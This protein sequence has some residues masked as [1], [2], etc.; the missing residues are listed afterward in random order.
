MSIIKQK[1][2]LI[3]K[4]NNLVQLKMNDDPI[5]TSPEG[6]EKDLPKSPKLKRPNHDE[7]TKSIQPSIQPPQ[8]LANKLASHKLLLHDAT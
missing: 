1:E 2:G 4:L 3:L 8:S 7:E 5:Y 6:Y